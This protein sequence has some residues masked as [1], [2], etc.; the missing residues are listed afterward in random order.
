LS[1]LDGIDMSIAGM[2]PDPRAY[3]I[4]PESDPWL[5]RRMLGF[6]ASELPMVLVA[7]GR[8]RADTLPRWMQDQ[9][10]VTNRTLGQPR[11]YAV[12]AGLVQQKR[13]GRAAA[14]GQEREEELLDEWRALL[15]RREYALAEEASINVASIRHARS[16]PRQWLP[17]RARHSD[18]IA[19]TP[20]AWCFD[21]AGRLY[22][23]ECKCVTTDVYEC[24]WYWR[25]QVQGQGMATGSDG[26]FVVCGQRWA[27]DNRN[28]GSVVRCFVEPDDALRS[29]LAEAADEAWEKVETLRASLNDAERGGN[30]DSNAS[31]QAGT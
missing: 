28:D 26:G 24:R 6:G 5:E 19:A 18:H 11:L 27:H 30:D 14:I 8:R 20:D 7:T 23:V 2:T 15:L 9:L 4:G 13:A 22:D 1:A 17:L 31:K 12:K 29:E 21:E 25:V 10:R 3:A 16:V